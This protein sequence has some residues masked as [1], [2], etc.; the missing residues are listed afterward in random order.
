MVRRSPQS[1]TLLTR[2][3]RKLVR[4][5]AE[6]LDEARYAAEDGLRLHPAETPKEQLIRSEL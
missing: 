3:T 4:L 1:K 2:K 6:G 5:H